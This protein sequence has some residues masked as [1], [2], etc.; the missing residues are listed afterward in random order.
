MEGSDVPLGSMQ[1][2]GELELLGEVQCWQH[3][4]C[5]GDA[6]NSRGGDQNSNTGLNPELLQSLV[7]TVFAFWYHFVEWGCSTRVNITVISNFSL[8]GVPVV[9]QRLEN[10]TSIHEDGAS[11]LG[12]A[13]WVKDPALP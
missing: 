12:L 6:A 8:F 13:P 2:R 11:S 1:V 5:T 3:P 9:A 10:L 4:T 7:L